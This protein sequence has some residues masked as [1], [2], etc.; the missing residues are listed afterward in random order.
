[1]VEVE[2]KNSPQIYI[3]QQWD[4]AIDLT[5]RRVVYGALAGGAAAVLLA[6]EAH[7]II[8]SHVIVEIAFEL[9]HV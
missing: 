6:S 4:Q 2:T 1:M 7:V 8:I 3:N 9:V 5:V